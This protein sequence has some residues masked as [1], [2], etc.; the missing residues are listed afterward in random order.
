M[1]PIA[2]VAAPMPLLYAW[3]GPGLV[4][5]L[6]GA[7]AGWLV[8]RR[9]REQVW[10]AL[11]AELGLED[12]SPRTHEELVALRRRLYRH[13]LFLISGI[14]G[15]NRRLV[16]RRGGADVEVL[17]FEGFGVGHWA[18]VSVRTAILEPERVARRIDAA[19]NRPGFGELMQ[20]AVV[21]RRGDLRLPRFILMPENYLTRRVPEPRGIAWDEG[22]AYPLFAQRNRLIAGPQ[23]A[24][25]AKRLFDR[26]VQLMLERNRDLTIEG[27]G[28]TLVLYRV[29]HAMTA[30]RVREL[31]VDALELCRLLAGRQPA[32]RAGDGTEIAEVSAPEGVESTAANY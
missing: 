24:A 8:L 6:A 9:Q 17:D 16:G 31:L 29:G 30:E 13:V 32:A 5:V 12:A 26:T 14:D 21:L 28:D 25:A 23:D 2:Q 27:E 19:R 10:S 22:E 18:P 7:F 1:L 15:V 20:T 4:L 11:A 3:L